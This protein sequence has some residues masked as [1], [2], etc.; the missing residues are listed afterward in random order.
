M[1]TQVREE[2]FVSLDH[3]DAPQSYYIRLIP[4]SPQTGV[5]RKSYRLP[6]GLLFKAGRWYHL[7]LDKAQ[8][9]YLLAK[10]QNIIN[11]NSPP[12]FQLV[13]SKSEFEDIVR[14]EKIAA[15]K[16]KG[17]RNP[18]YDAELMDKEPEVKTPNFG[19]AAATGTAVDT[20][21]IGLRKPK[22]APAAAQAAPVVTP[23]P[24]AP[25]FNIKA[26]EVSVSDLAK[27]TVAQAVANRKKS[28]AST[29]QRGQNKIGKK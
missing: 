11:P 29:A 4:A 27:T 10:R 20:S 5:G 17:P 6:G 28:V 9:D 8:R 2:D 25:T 12:V 7:T 18:E 1:N 15:M 23:P 22:D 13:T 26:K 16:A 24:P 3:E 19:V 14:R 21:R